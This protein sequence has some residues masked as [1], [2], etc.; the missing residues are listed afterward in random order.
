[1]V[2]FCL[3]KHASGGG[4]IRPICAFLHTPSSG[5][6]WRSFGP[7]FVP[8]PARNWLPCYPPPPR[9]RKGKPVPRT[10]VPPA[11]LPASLCVVQNPVCFSGQTRRWVCPFRLWPKT[12]ACTEPSRLFGQASFSS[13]TAVPFCNP[14][15][16]P[17]SQEERLVFV[18][19]AAP[20][21]RPICQ[22]ASPSLGAF[23]E[24]RA[25]PAP[26]FV[27]SP[28]KPACGSCAP[29]FALG[30]GVSGLHRLPAPR[31]GVAHPVLKTFETPPKPPHGK[32]YVSGPANP[33]PRPPRGILSS[34]STNGSR[35]L[36]STLYRG[37]FIRG[38]SVTPA[39]GCFFFIG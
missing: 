22:I 13:S 31:P 25:R 15:Q 17:R 4:W 1:L 33:S 21:P 37:G 30:L 7:G 38:D 18:P 9:P 12:P 6:P 24:L 10:L 19:Q 36:P 28:G 35:H 29:M 39:A 27:F 3:P 34:V 20:N 8:P 5:F 11:I 14:P 26:V 23:V 16:S 32:F 2:G